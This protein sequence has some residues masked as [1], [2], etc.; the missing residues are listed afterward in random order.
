MGRLAPSGGAVTAGN[1]RGEPVE[2]Q[3][4]NR[5]RGET[6]LVTSSDSY[7]LRL[8]NAK[9]GG[10]AVYGCR[11]PD[12]PPAQDLACLYS[13][14][15]REV[16]QDTTLTDSRSPKSVHLQCPAGKEIIGGGANVSGAIGNVAF[17]QNGPDSQLHTWET[18]AQEVDAQAGNWSLAATVY[19]A[20]VAS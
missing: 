6:G 7:S 11:A 20:N 8:S 14:N 3:V 5:S 17:A 10:G 1:S 2:I 18:S 12:A 15:L 19:C 13:D 9:E 4:R 16:V